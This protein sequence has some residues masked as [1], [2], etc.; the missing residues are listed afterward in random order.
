M[1]R[2]LRLNLIPAPRVIS[3]G[4]A[5]EFP[6][7]HVD[8]KGSER[9]V[10]TLSEARALSR[11]VAGSS[12]DRSAG[13]F[14]SEI[15][16]IEQTAEVVVSGLAGEWRRT[17]HNISEGERAKAISLAVR[18]TY[19]LGLNRSLVT[20]GFGLGGPWV[21]HVEPEGPGG[22]W[23]LDD[24]RGRNSPI[25][26]LG[27]KAE[28]IAVDPRTGRALGRFFDVWLTPEGE[29]ILPRDRQTVL[30]GDGRTAPKDYLWISSPVPRREMPL[31]TRF[32]FK[33]EP[34]PTLLRALDRSVAVLGMMFCRAHDARERNG[35]GEGLLGSYRFAGDG[36][37]EYTTVPS[38]LG[39]PRAMRRLCEAV[40]RE[41][42]RY[43]ENAVP[44]EC[45]EGGNQSA[46][47]SVFREDT[48]DTGEARAFKNKYELWKLHLESLYRWQRAYYHADKAFF[49]SFSGLEPDL[50]PAPEGDFRPRWGLDAPAFHEACVTV[51]TGIA[52]AGSKSRGQEVILRAGARSA[53]VKMENVL[54]P[55]A[56]EADDFNRGT[57]AWAP[58][59]L[60]RPNPSAARMLGL[61]EEAVLR[62]NVASGGGPLRIGPII[63]IVAPMLSKGQ[64]F[65]VETDRFR[66]MVRLGAEMGLL[67]YVFFPEVPPG[68]GPVWD[69]V[70]GLVKGWTYRD[71]RG[72]LEERLPLP[73]VVYD[74]YIQAVSGGARDIAQEFSDACP[75][76]V[77]LNSLPLVRACRDKLVTYEILAGV[78]G[79][80]PHLPYT[81]AVRE[82]SQVAH[83][84][85]SRQ[86]SFLKPRF[87]TG[88]KGLALIENLG[89]R[90]RITRREKG[91]PPRVDEVQGEAGLLRF[92]SDVL[93]IPASGDKKGRETHPEFIIQEGIDLCPLP[94]GAGSAFEVRVVYQKGGA[95]VWMRTGMVVRANPEA[96]GFVV[97]GV[98]LHHRAGDFLELALPGRADEVRA[99]V[100]RVARMIPPA[101]ERRSGR[102]GE[103]SVDFGIDRKGKPWLI[104]V[105]SKP[106]TLFRDTG[107]FKLR[108]LTL[109]R[110]LN[111]AI[112]LHQEVHSS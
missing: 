33:G 36:L 34:A 93:P 17:S 5:T 110:V 76:A 14:F 9:V 13:D 35:T 23:G 112:F 39:S 88:T 95:G 92:F 106:A 68:D 21:V 107:A 51:G 37:F 54:G 111:Y 11:A 24:V 61:S 99:E 81:E 32:V 69:P 105:N 26:F 71:R 55:D 67:V 104:E 1:L 91:V 45:G 103:M 6:V 80:A 22:A 83:F 42:A 58:A 74:R 48:E 7:L 66:H 4:P 3:P 52:F 29:L 40:S 102:G 31:S 49:H 47:P 59:T 72:W 82:P 46:G 97:P 100:R 78:P 53:S 109:L 94:A 65:G 70:A 108:K 12:R 75:R 27:A 79:I 98:E 64:K 41:V 96:E 86:R 25:R 77:F 15:L 90:Y 57:S 28:Y 8:A 2:V 19:A 50:P 38:L 84:A 30:R 18:A 20:I 10:R 16:P 73:D 44:A 85:S 56:L 87:G 101:L 60:A 89:S 63:G 43:D 62:A